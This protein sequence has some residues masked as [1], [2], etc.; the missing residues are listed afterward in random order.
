MTSWVGFKQTGVYYARQ[1][2]FA[3][4]TKYP[5]RRM[6]KFASDAITGFSFVPL[7]LATFLGFTIAALSGVGVLIV[8]LG[9]LFGNQAFLGQATTL[10]MV[11]FLGGVQLISLGIIGEY[12]GRIYDEVKGRPMYIVKEAV[13]FDESRAVEERILEREVVGK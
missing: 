9:R 6:L 2:R 7:Q 5:L 10:V 12:L 3:G 1:E 8:I 4:E 13:G 11:L